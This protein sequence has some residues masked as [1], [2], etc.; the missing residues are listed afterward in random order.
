M[1]VVVATGEVV[2]EF[3]DEQNR[4]ERQGE[5]EAGD[6]CERMLVEERES[7]EKFVEVY[8]F[9]FSVGCGEMGTGD[10]AGAE[11]DEEKKD[12]EEERF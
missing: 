11:G 6:E 2:A 10:E 1:D 5:R 9:V 3:V 4:E 12:R 8:G 7:V